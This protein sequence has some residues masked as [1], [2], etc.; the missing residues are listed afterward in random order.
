MHPRIASIASAS[1]VFGIAMPAFCGDSGDPE[2]VGIRVVEIQGASINLSTEI[3]ESTLEVSRTFVVDLGADASARMNLGLEVQG[4]SGGEVSIDVISGS[5]LV[6]E[7]GVATTVLVPADPDLV[8]LSAGNYLVSAGANAHVSFTFTEQMPFGD[9]DMTIWSIVA[10]DSTVT[11]HPSG[12]TGS[13]WLGTSGSPDAE[14][15]AQFRVFGGKGDTAERSLVW[16][17]EVMGSGFSMPEEGSDE[18]QTTFPVGYSTIDI[19]PNS[20]IAIVL[21]RGGDSDDG[22]S[23]TPGDMDGDGDADEV[24]YALLGEQLGICPGDLDGDGEVGGSDIGLLLV[25]WGLCP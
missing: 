19:E 7:L 4:D 17:N 2:G 25:G 11:F 22:S 3:D 10:E 24:D 18:V 14:V 5:V 6:R 21:D 23:G 8:S 16:V 1:I 12:D 9:G 20:L 13:L 15:T